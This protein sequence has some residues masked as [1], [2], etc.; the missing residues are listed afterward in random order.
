MSSAKT[1]TARTFASGKSASGA[2]STTYSFVATKPTISPNGGRY[3]KG[4][5]EA[6]SVM[7]TLSNNSSAPIYYTLS[8][9]SPNS[10]AA[11]PTTVS[12]RYTG[13]FEL[14]GARCAYRYIQLK[15][16]AI[17]SGDLTSVTVSAQFTL[18]GYGKDCQ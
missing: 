17:G 9:G 2:V 1:I 14:M 4:R 3:S 12:T 6:P 15:A 10:A 13:R 7:I 5:G 18:R 8:S 16:R 11:T